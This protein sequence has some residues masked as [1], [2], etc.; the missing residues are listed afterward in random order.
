[1]IVGLCTI[2]LRIPS[3]RSLKGK[4]QVIR[5]IKDRLRNRFNISVAEVDNLDKWQKA[6]L[7][8]AFV[9]KD[10]GFVEKNLSKLVDFIENLHL[11][12]IVDYQI[13]IL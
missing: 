4:R 6:T 11:A 3:N 2:E 5:S 1:M 10:K 12:E 9:N 8:I 7:G 13:E